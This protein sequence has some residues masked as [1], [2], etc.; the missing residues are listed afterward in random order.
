MFV[1]SGPPAFD[2]LLCFKWFWNSCQVTGGMWSF[3][4]ETGHVGEWD[5]TSSTKFW[6]GGVIWM[7]SKMKQ[8]VPKNFSYIRRVTRELFG[9]RISDYERLQ[10]FRADGASNSGFHLD[11]SDQTT[12]KLSLRFGFVRGP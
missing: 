1:L 6:G 7:P 9:V 8:G 4:A 11:P 5:R 3:L 12:V 10:V 2:G